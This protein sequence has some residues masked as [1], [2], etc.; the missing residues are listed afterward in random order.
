MQS[1]TTYWSH[2]E[3]M[4]NGLILLHLM[5]ALA[6]GIMMGYER[7]YHG[8]AAGMRTYAL[9]CVA[10]TLLTVLTGFPSEWYGGTAAVTASADPTRIIQGVMTGIGFLGAGVI[11]REGL[12]VRGLSTAASIWIT[13]A[14]GIAIGVGFYGAAICTA[15][16]T[17]AIMSGFRRLE[18]LLPHQTELHV[19]LVLPRQT[20]PTLRQLE[21]IVRQ[22][23]TLL[24]D[25][26]Y[27]HGR[28]DQPVEYQLILRSTN[29]SSAETLAEEL[30]RNPDILD[31]TISPSRT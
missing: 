4:T 26:T 25:W 22:H 30:A 3:L 11:M 27:R 14:I 8:R 2:D 6:V 5:G 19:S 21:D 16:I 24:T 20:A 13:A 23:H 18:V 1:L 31:F 12:S 10:S 7:S 17:I 15:L 28:A 29:R 9:V